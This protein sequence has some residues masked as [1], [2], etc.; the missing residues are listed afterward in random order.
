MGKNTLAFDEIQRQDILLW[1]EY[2]LMLLTKVKK[3]LATYRMFA[4]FFL[5]YKIAL[6]VIQK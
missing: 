1:V 5:V 6:K 3:M 2:L 4:C